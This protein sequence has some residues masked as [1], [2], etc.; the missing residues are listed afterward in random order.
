MSE[1]LAE[2]ILRKTFD[3][4]GWVGIDEQPGLAQWDVTIEVTP[5]EIAY[6]KR[7]WAESPRP[8]GDE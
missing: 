1:S 2:S 7:L 8:Q 3:D 4:A 5:E 6:L